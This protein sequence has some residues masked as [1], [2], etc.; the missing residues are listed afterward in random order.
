M[1]LDNEFPII[2]Y[3]AGE[4][5]RY[6]IRPVVGKH[7]PGATQPYDLPKGQ[8]TRSRGKQRLAVYVS[9]ANPISE[10]GSN[11]AARKII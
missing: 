2:A 4:S 5:R 9:G 3:T 1:T 10:G 11:T 6:Q 7:I 8:I